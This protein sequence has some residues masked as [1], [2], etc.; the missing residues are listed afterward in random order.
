[1]QEL[2]TKDSMMQGVP[3]GLGVGDL[4]MAITLIFSGDIWSGLIRQHKRA[5][6]MHR[7]KNRRVE[8]ILINQYFQFADTVWKH[9]ES[10]GKVLDDYLQDKPGTHHG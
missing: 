6:C 1:M 10:T 7:N 9:L 3:V 4:P 5:L 8:L 2:H